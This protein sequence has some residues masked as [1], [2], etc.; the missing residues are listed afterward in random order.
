MNMRAT[1]ID[2]NFGPGPATAKPS[3]PVKIFRA[4]DYPLD[5]S[6]QGVV[7]GLLDHGSMSVLFGASNSGKTFI[8]VSIAWAVALDETWH[9]MP[10]R[11]GI[12]V[13]VAAENCNSVAT[14]IRA[15]MLHYQ[16]EDPPLYLVPAYV[17]LHSEH[18]SVGD[19][20]GH[21]RRISDT[22]GEVVLVVIDTLARTMG[23][24]DENTARDMGALVANV[25][26][27][28]AETGAHVMVIHHTGKEATNGA[29]GSSALRAAT[30]TELEVTDFVLSVKKQRDHDGGQ[31]FGFER[32]PV[33][34]SDA[35]GN[36][37]SSLV[38]VPMG[39]AP[40]RAKPA[41]RRA[42]PA[43]AVVAQKALAK[44]LELAGQE[45]PR[46][47]ETQ[48]VRTAVKMVMWRNYF[49]QMAG[50]EETDAAAC[51]KAFDRARQQL[52]AS[53]HAR[54]W[55]QWVFATS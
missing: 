3:L 22:E 27:L 55:G 41:T 45:P 46:C 33:T 28:R 50:Y 6:S 24:G 4:A 48:G 1:V 15:C 54:V 49:Q 52:I 13:Y 5:F 39:D 9:G 35:N 21:I 38:L 19:L 23:A 14:R 37:R 36:T 12:V 42:L 40:E 17:D 53:G 32:V 34:V 44:A 30:D 25:D 7:A 26:K 43:N 16:V 11:G 2:H 31:S 18:G 51:R 10:M 29:R 47:D 20:I 8:A